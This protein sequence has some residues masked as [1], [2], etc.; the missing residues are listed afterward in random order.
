M[1]PQRIIDARPFSTVEELEP[2]VSGIGPITLQN[3]KDQG[4][5]C[6]ADENAQTTEVEEGEEIVED[7]KV[8]T[9]GYVV[10][11]YVQTPKNVTF[12]SIS[13][14]AKDIK[15]PETS[16]VEENQKIDKN[17]F[18]MYGFVGFSLLIGLLLIIK[19]RKYV[20]NEFR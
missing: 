2:K 17:K 20:E 18:V 3:I 5:A 15:N 16:E 8:Q 14:G 1:D 7:K 9:T 12:D 4:L 10:E 11:N 13:L 19:K 6:V